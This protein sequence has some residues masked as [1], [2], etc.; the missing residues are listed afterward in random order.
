MVGCQKNKYSSSWPPIITLTCIV[1]NWSGSSLLYYTIRQVS[2]QLECYLRRFPVVY[3]DLKALWED[4]RDR[5]EGV[6]SQALD[7][8]QRGWVLGSGSKPLPTSAMLFGEY[9]KLP[10]RL[11]LQ[12]FYTNFDIHDGPSDT[13]RLLISK[14]WL[15]V[16]WQET[17]K[18]SRRE[19]FPAT[20]CQDIKHSSFPSHYLQTF[21]QVIAVSSAK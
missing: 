3:P 6:R 8:W 19:S 16:L 15:G 13:V 7:S 5:T 1:N 14:C 12:K 11:L 20:V 21:A 2:T 17:G 18:H 9:C 10:S 4:C